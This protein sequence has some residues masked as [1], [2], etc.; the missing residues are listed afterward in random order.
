M[1]THLPNF[2]CPHCGQS[3]AGSVGGV[4]TEL[5]ALETPAGW[6]VVV[7]CPRPECR[8][9]IGVYFRPKS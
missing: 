1:S 4:H 6:P 5:S 8:R 7:S 2:N 3:I 9:A